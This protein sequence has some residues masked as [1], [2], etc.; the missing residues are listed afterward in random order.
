MSAKRKKIEDQSTPLL[1]NLR[2]QAVEKGLLYEGNEKHK[3]PWQA[4][5]RG[6][7]CPTEVTVEMAQ[8]ILF[9]RSVADGDKQRFGADSSGRA[10]CA[11]SHRE[12]R[13]HGYPVGWKEVPVKFQKALHYLGLVTTRELKKYYS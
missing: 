12:G 13:W 7:L 11:R 8:E 3:Y 4:G 5:R 10:Y 6:S 1:L 9:E 2:R